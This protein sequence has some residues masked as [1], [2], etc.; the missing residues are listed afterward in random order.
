VGV[1]VVVGRPQGV[2]LALNGS[3]TA[4]GRSWTT[5]SWHRLA[6]SQWPRGAAASCAH[7]AQ[8]PTAAQGKHSW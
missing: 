5:P 4:G 7:H 1:E 8:P 6:G 2:A 3:P